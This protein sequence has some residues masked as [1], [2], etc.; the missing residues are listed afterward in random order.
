VIFCGIVYDNSSKDLV[1]NFGKTKNIQDPTTEGEKML[2]RSIMSENVVTVEMDETLKTIQDLFHQLKFHHLL[3]VSGTRV[4][5]VISDRDFLQ[6]VSPFVGTVSEYTRDLATLQKR[7]HQIM[8]HRP[9]TVSPDM[10]VADAAQLLLANN[11]SC[12]PVVSE[13][14]EIKGIITWKD[15]IRALL[16]NRRDFS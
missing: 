10:K 14:D 7:A 12:L 6:A 13:E 9:I 1:N 16:K 15:L 5:G 8:S 2:V 3:V 4:L 11:I